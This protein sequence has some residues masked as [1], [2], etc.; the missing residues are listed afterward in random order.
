MVIIVGSSLHGL[1]SVSSSSVNEL[2][3]S[4]GRVTWE[5]R[6]VSAAVP[7]SHHHLC[8]YLLRVLQRLQ[9]HLRALGPT[10]ANQPRDV[11]DA[12]NRLQNLQELLETHIFST[13]QGPSRYCPAPAF[14]D[15]PESSRASLSAVG[16]QMIPSTS[17]LKGGHQFPHPEPRRREE[18]RR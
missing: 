2:L 4:P 7:E 1:G 9:S 15:H 13:D 11:L 6:A 10:P 3:P 8:C 14:P 5:P 12:T 17:V 18:A 16:F